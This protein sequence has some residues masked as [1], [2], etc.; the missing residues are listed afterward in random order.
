MHTLRMQAEILQ[1]AYYMGN[2]FLGHF[3]NIVIS[4]LD[5]SCSSNLAIILP[6]LKK[7][8]ATNIGI[9]IVW[10]AITIWEAILEFNIDIAILEKCPK[11]DFL[12]Q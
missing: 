6:L 11:I 12:I 7:E 8:R 4:I 3:S 2:L 1:V 9:A 10:R 5:Y